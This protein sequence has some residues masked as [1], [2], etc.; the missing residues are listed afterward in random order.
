MSTR[1]SRWLLLGL[2]LLIGADE[3]EGCKETV[4]GLAAVIGAAWRSGGNAVLVL[5]S[6]A[7]PNAGVAIDL[8]EQPYPFDTTTDQSFYGEERLVEVAGTTDLHGFRFLCGVTQDNPSLATHVVFWSDDGWSG[9]NQTFPCGGD[10][11]PE[12]KEISD[13]ITAAR[14]FC[15]VSE[16]APPQR[17]DRCLNG[18]RCDD[19]QR[20]GSESDVDCGGEG[21]CPR[22]RENRG[23]VDDGDCLSSASCRGGR[24]KSPTCSDGIRNQDE[25]DIDC[26][27][28]CDGCDVGQ[29]CNR[30]SDCES[31]NCDAQVCG[32]RLTC[33]GDPD[34]GS[35]QTYTVFAKNA[36]GCGGVYTAFANSLDDAR[37]CEPSGWSA[38]DQMCEFWIQI[39]SDYETLVRGP[40]EQDAINCVRRTVCSSCAL[41]VNQSL[42]CVYQ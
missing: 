9:T 22:C 28:R 19:Q 16:L 14:S 20:N 26:G 7:R 32:P 29:R 27:G 36:Y 42:G 37:T 33:N 24:C 4:K 35:G 38:V 13:S 12:S 18:P 40:S 1:F 21:D 30:A 10:S 11:T 41:S 2:P 31:S 17:I 6:D 25:S 23:C 15:V 3:C 34:S 5:E 39:G 8:T